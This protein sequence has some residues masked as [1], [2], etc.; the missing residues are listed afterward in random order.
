MCIIHALNKWRNALRNEKNFIASCIRVKNIKPIRVEVR[1][2]KIIFKF[3]GLPVLKKRI[4]PCSELL[5]NNDFDID[6]RFYKKHLQ[7]RF[8]IGY[9]IRRVKVGDI[10]VLL[11][12]KIIPL[13]K[14]AAYLYLSDP[15]IN[16]KIYRAYLEKHGEVE[17]T[18]PRPIE[19]F[20]ELLC[21]LESNGY[22]PKKIIIINKDNLLADGQHRASFLYHKYGPNYEVNVLTLLLVKKC[23]MENK[24]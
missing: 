3:L 19:R 24:V 2:N 15:K 17:K 23:Y 18:Q 21:C 22:N 8:Y 10:K 7:S 14:T 12:D 20:Q 11:Y 5:K 16:H 6:P 13:N 4:F 9:K 1:G